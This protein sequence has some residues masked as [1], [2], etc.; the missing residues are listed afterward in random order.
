MSP[1]YLLPPPRSGVWA[2]L[3]VSLAVHAQV[4]T[5]RQAREL[6][7]SKRPREAYE[8]LS[9]QE[10]QHAGE[11]EFDLLLG[12]AANEAGEFTRAIMA[13][14]RVMSSEPGNTQ[15]RAELGR[16]LYAVG[17]RKAAR[18]LLA[19]SKLEGIIAIAGENVEQLLHAIDRT[20]A[21][22]RSSA[23]A[24]V[25][26]AVGHDSNIN[27]APGVSNVA[28][29][30]YG[31]SILAVDPAGT[32]K[33][34]AFTS[35][36]AGSSGRLVLGPRLSL[37]GAATVRGQR[38]NDADLHANSVQVDVQ[39]GMAYRVEREEYSLA[40]QVGTYRIGGESLRDNYG[41]VG[42]WTY[43]FDG[44]RQFNAYIQ[45][46]RLV[47]PTQHIADAN[48]TVI[49]A[50][51]AHLTRGGIWAYGGVYFGEEAVLDPTAPHLGHKV[52][53]ARGGMQFPVRESVRG[54]VS[55]GYEQRRYGGQDPLF[56]ITRHDG[57]V[58]V[59]LGLSWVPAPFWRITPQFSWTRTGSTV[60]LAQYH[61][62]A[63]SLAALRE[64]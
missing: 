36:T 41:L 25:E 4:D 33:S 45:A 56:L 42:E 32:R 46:G 58:N 20:E 44:F 39:G 43:R 19:E 9:A 2:A 49:G 60:P 22:G 5:V 62:R 10:V 38:F 8:L 63:L 15:A 34:G 18:A 57:Q 51:Y 59:S 14:E 54:F 24:Y 3:L 35:A 28:V 26:L 6:L 61:K 30:A 64:F 7:A 11:V 47:Y 27:S 48:R 53:G 29:P 37:I 23:R 52:A 12:A 16:A 55:G 17:D 13:L 50:T 31:G 21:D 40:A 1:C